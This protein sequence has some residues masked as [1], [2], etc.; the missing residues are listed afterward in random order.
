ML[1]NIEGKPD[2]LPLLDA[3]GVLGSQSEVTR[4]AEPRVAFIAR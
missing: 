3:L 4:T 1:W 2:L